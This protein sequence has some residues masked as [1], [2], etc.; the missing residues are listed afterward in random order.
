MRTS[1]PRGTPAVLST[2][3]FLSNAHREKYLS[4]GY[5]D[6]TEDVAQKA[7]CL[8]PRTFANTLR[9]IKAVL[10]VPKTPTG[11]PSKSRTEVDPTAYAALIKEHKIGQPL[12]VES[13]MKE[14]HSALVALPRY[15][16][17]FASHIADSGPDVRIAVFFWVCQTIKV[18]NA[19]LG[20]PYFAY[21]QVPPSSQ[22]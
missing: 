12:R 2:R 11:S 8:K 6:V 13:W 1:R 4:A 20:I 7:S 5:A 9:T 22:I 17:K 3:I 18:R 15:Q 21:Q 16:R 10:H 19:N 14:A